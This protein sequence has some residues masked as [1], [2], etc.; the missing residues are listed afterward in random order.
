MKDFAGKTAVIT[1]GA[2][3]IGRAM[4]ALFLDKGMNVV[5]A[6]I[7]Q[8]ALD[9]TVA[10][11]NSGSDRCVEAGGTFLGEWVRAAEPR[12]VVT[13]V[14]RQGAAP[15]AGGSRRMGPAG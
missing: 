6:D 9:E 12:R 15:E 14:S 7:E 10:A 4:G 3:G 1:G 13:G 2:S 8:K 5:L 11:L